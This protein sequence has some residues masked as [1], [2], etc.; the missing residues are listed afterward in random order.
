MQLIELLGSYLITNQTIGG[1]RIEV[2]FL[3]SAN[4]EKWPPA[5]RAKQ[6]GT[7]DLEK[8]LLAENNQLKAELDKNMDYILN[9]K[10]HYEG[11]IAKERRRNEELE[12][13][14][15]V[16]E[17]AQKKLWHTYESHLQAQKTVVN[18]KEYGWK[19]LMSKIK[20]LEASNEILENNLKLADRKVLGLQ[21]LNRSLEA[22]I[23]KKQIQRPE[24]EDEDEEEQDDEA[25]EEPPP[26]FVGEHFQVFLE[27]YLSR[28]KA[29]KERIAFLTSELVALDTTEGRQA[30]LLN[31]ASQQLN[32]IQLAWLEVALK[33]RNS[34]LDFQEHLREFCLSLFEVSEEA[35]AVFARSLGLPAASQVRVWAREPSGLGLATATATI[36]AIF[37]ES[38]PA[39]ANR[40]GVGDDK[41]PA[42]A[43][44][45]QDSPPLKRRRSVDEEDDEGRA[46]DEDEEVIFSEDSE[47]EAT[48]GTVQVTA[49]EERGFEAGVAS[50]S[51]TETQQ[52]DFDFILEEEEVT[53]QQVEDDSAQ[54]GSSMPLLVP[55]SPVTP[56]PSLG[57][58]TQTPKI[59]SG[60]KKVITTDTSLPSGSKIVFRVIES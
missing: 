4:M 32:Q 6:T 38:Q 43:R 21:D 51:V 54:V 14:I 42:K 34:A 37:E 40:T 10:A 15:E 50:T 11:I 3:V 52:P 46:S 7:T 58:A 45:P 47:D 56:I 5:S 53:T 59:S 26:C 23:G 9:Q 16:L 33:G 36:D 49:Q 48:A 39:P 27:H 44:G 60:R 35:Y 8:K 31:L 20:Q 25:S 17:T 2:K 41:R 18:T 55:D 24:G 22:K 28:E 12:S 1:V 29:L 19:E 13:K 30:N 57:A